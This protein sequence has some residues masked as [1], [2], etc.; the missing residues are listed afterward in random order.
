MPRK[1]KRKRKRKVKTRVRVRVP[2]DIVRHR[3]ERLSRRIAKVKTI[4]L[5]VAVTVAE[6][7]VIWHVLGVVNAPPTRVVLQR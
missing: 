3:R 5:W 7:G 4:L 1:L 6:A 2:L